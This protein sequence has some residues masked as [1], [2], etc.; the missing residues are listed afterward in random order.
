VLRLLLRASKWLLRR[1]PAV[2][3]L[4]YDLFNQ[5]VFSGLDWHERM[6]TDSV[7]VESYRTGI[8][9]AV[10]P[11][12]VVIDLGTGTGVL[13]V[14]AARAGARQVYAIDHSPFIAVAQEIAR[15]NQVANI[16]FV[17]KNSREFECPEPVDLI[18]HEQMGHVIFDENLLQNLLDLKR[19]ALKPGGRILPGRFALLA[20]PVA[21]KDEY[22]KPLLWELDVP[23][24]RLSSLA[25]HPA[26]DAYRTVEHRHRLLKGFEVEAF[27]AE[28]QA[29]I[30]VDINALVTEHDL[31]TTYDVQWPVTRAGTVDGICF[32]FRTTFDD[33]TTF[34]TSP[35]S[36]QTNWEN[37]LIRTAQRAV[38]PGES[39][40]YTLHLDPLTTR[41]QWRIDEPGGTPVTMLP[42]R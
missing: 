28:P 27:L 26:L 32:F 14:F 36:R 9:S 40:G 31:A 41:Q 35:F 19:R 24:F 16:T 30:Q 38:T 3:K 21:L 39:I 2:Q 13:A 10:K 33:G 8:T 6:L 12:D 25:K 20:A 7:R 15:A 23:G 1:F 5:E 34:D 11:G 37:A 42:K 4:R 17:Q 22:R 29:L 18:I